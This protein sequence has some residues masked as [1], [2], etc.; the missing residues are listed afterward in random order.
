MNLTCFRTLRFLFFLHTGTLS[1]RNQILPA[2]SSWRLPF[3]SL[4][5]SLTITRANRNFYIIFMLL[6]QVK[7][8]VL[9]HKMCVD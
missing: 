1:L 4:S 8:C 5:Q 6:R 3:F 7:I 9:F 2:A